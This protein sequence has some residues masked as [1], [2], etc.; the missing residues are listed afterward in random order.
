MIDYKLESSYIL[1][2]VLYK[3]IPSYYMVNTSHSDNIDKAL[4]F[5]CTVCCMLSFLFG[6]YPEF[7][8]KVDKNRLLKTARV[9]RTCRRKNDGKLSNP[10]C[11]IAHKTKSVII[12]AKNYAESEIPLNQIEKSVYD[13]KA[14]HTKYVI[15]VMQ[16]NS[17]L[18]NSAYEYCLANKVILIQLSTIGTIIENDADMNWMKLDRLYLT[19]ENMR[20]LRAEVERVFM[21]PPMVL[22]TKYN[23]VD[24]R[25]KAVVR[26]EPLPK[27]GHSERSDR[28]VDKSCEA[29]RRYKDYKD[30]TKA[31]NYN[32]S[33]ARERLKQHQII[34]KAQNP[35]NPIANKSDSDSRVHPI[36]KDSTIRRN[37]GNN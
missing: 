4:A 3:S 26:N 34:K 20:L 9:E 11:Q 8:I 15:I 28:T 21:E 19:I 2:L 10:D 30:K 18:S 31:S 5:E 16:Q 6:N 36:K 13:A 27:Y 1:I 24:G 17:A 32:H 12:D 29:F 14:K 33:Q 37:P 25:C 23:M 22:Y 35:L 7:R